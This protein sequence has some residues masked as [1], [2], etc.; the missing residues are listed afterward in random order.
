VRPSTGDPG[1]PGW[2]ATF[3]AGCLAR[4]PFRVQVA[5]AS[6]AGFDSISIWPNIWRHAQLRDSLT[7]ANMRAMLADHGLALTDADAC[8]DWVPASSDPGRV[9]GPMR[10]RVSRAEFFGMC[11]ALGGTTVV[12]VHLTDAGLDLGRDTE[13]FA[14]LCDD[15]SE[16]GLRVA[17]EFFPFSNVPDLDTAWRIVSGADRANG[18][19]VLDVCHYVRSGR[20]DELLARI[21]PGR[22]YTVQL[23]D[24][25]ATA[26]DDL[27]REAM[28]ERMLPGT[29]DFDVPAFLALLDGMGVRAACGPELYSPSFDD[30]PASE[31]AAELSRAL[32]AVLPASTSSKEREGA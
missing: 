8:F 29:G 25:P 2:R 4:T 14:A 28:Y 9:H 20:D 21:P 15:A 11:A 16:H 6:A 23:A 19:L 7:P 12:A 1:I 27:V 24:G 32:R 22:I 17:L 10:R 31:V 18:G 30:R 26:P 3:M 5:A 13:G